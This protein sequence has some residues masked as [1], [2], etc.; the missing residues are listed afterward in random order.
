MKEFYDHVRKNAY[1][2]SKV[3]MDKTKKAMNRTMA[4]IDAHKLQYEINKLYREIGV[5]TYL[6]AKG[7]M[8]NP[9]KRIE[10][11]IQR[12]D[13]KYSQIDGRMEQGA[14]TETPEEEAEVVV[15]VAEIEDLTEKV[16]MEPEENTEGLKVMR[17]CNHC[18][19]GNHPEATHCV[20][21]GQKL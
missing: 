11:L 12:I 15:E 9:S 6:A 21:C 14:T 2:G 10:K 18:Q 16:V 8:D 5:C 4:E 13:E 1:A 19:V 17:F 7:K 20:K 3:F